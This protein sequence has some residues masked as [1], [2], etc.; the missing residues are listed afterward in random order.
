MRKLVIFFW[1]GT[2]VIVVASLYFATCLGKVAGCLQADAYGG[3]CR[4]WQDP[5]LQEPGG[6]NP[7]RAAICTPE[8]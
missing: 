5:N 3:P 2:L 8:G 4:G 7:Y 1:A 6:G